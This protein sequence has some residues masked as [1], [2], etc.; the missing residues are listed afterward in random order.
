M[1]IFAVMVGIPCSGK[2]TFVEREFA[3]YKAIS[4]DAI[5]EN[6]AEK[7][8][9]TYND[10]W[11]NM[12]EHS[13]AFRKTFDGLLMQTVESQSDLVVDRTSLTIESRARVLAFATPVYR[14]VAVMLNTPFRV[15]LSRNAAR[16][17]SGKTIPEAVMFEMYDRLQLPSE[18]E[19]FDRVIYLDSS[20]EETRY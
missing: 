2:S 15:C 19:G 12:S 11:K 7:E 17:S 3:S 4:F 8:G 5:V 6:L 20:R 18:S 9:V 1:P 10:I 16:S 14:K 13:P